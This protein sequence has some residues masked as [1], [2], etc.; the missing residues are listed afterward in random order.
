[1]ATSPVVISFPYIG[2]VT[3]TDVYIRSGPGTNYYRCGKLNAPEKVEVV[4]SEN[5]WSKIMPPAGCF[6]WIS[7]QYVSLDADN[8]GQGHIT[9]DNVN[10]RAGSEFVPAI[11]SASLQTKLN[12]GAKVKL[13]GEEMDEYYKIV[14]PQGAYLW[15]S[16]EFLKNTGPAG[17]SGG[18][19]TADSNTVEPNAPPKTI[20]VES[21]KLKEYRQLS[22]Q[23]ALERAKPVA[24]QNWTDIKTK[25]AEIADN[26]DAGKAARYAAIQLENVKGFELARDA[27]KDIQQQQ[28]QLT[29]TRE[30]IEKARQEQLT[31]LGDL[32]KFAIVG[33]IRPS[34]L[35]AKS[36]KEYRYLILGENNKIIAYALPAES[37]ANMDLTQFFGKKVGLVGTIDRDPQTSSTLIR[38]TDVVEM[39]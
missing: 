38:F 6:S 8:P 30:Q 10:V 22:Q 32:G 12:K 20:S 16:S 17:K 24:E 21:E 35:Y 11:Q 34:L 27:G 1:M 4:G 15:V 18:I 29:Q 26:N 25:L 31:K 19:V 9:G 5:S 37:A 13:L 33:K 7:K 23:V 28:S 2:E 3:G 39:K 14:P 36:S